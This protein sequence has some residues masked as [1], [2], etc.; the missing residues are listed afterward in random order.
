MWALCGFGYWLQGFRCF[1]WLALNF[2]LTHGL[3]LGPLALQ[4]VQNTANLPMVAKPLYGMLSD[5]VYIGGAHRLPTSPSEVGLVLGDLG[6]DAHN[7]GH[8]SDADGVHPA[9]ESRGVLH[10][11]RQR[12]PRRR[13]QQRKEEG[14]LPAVVLVH[15]LGGGGI[16]GN[17]SG[18]FAL[19]GTQQPKLMFL[20][21]ALL[22]TAQLGVALTTQRRAYSRP[23]AP[24]EKPGQAVLRPDQSHKQREPATTALV[25]CGLHSRRAAPLGTIFCFQTQSL[26]L[27]PVV[28]GLS[29]VM[30]QMMV[31]SASFVYN[32]HLKEIPFRKL[33][34]WVQ[35]VY[36]ISLLSDLVLVQQVN[37]KMGISNEAY[38]LC[39]SA[40]AEAV[41]QFRI[42]PFS[43]LLAGLCPRG[44]EGSLF[45]FFASALCMSS[46]VSGV[47][48]VGL[49][50]LVGVGG[51]GDS[52]G[53]SVGIALQFMAALVPLR[54]I[55]LLPV[56]AKLP[57]RS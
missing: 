1:P 21:F 36:A 26:K 11:G 55:S 22:L 3:G 44:C 16:M 38:V 14:G 29:K 40:I 8:A 48:G 52:A 41:A 32:R 13:I 54:W 37:L 7:Q 27:D 53:L 30:G 4:L 5:A 47:F 57:T 56:G 49:A 19:V 51:A 35:I 45:A 34:F 42:L 33:I 12:C 25:D 24:W 39:L 18:G 20:S 50:T 23:R 46:I 6:A 28:I 2:H 43:V 17:L 31:L 10:R 15:G 9:R